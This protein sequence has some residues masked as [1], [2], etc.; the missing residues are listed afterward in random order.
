MEEVTPT[1]VSETPNGAEPQGE[2]PTPSETSETLETTDTSSSSPEGQVPEELAKELE[3]LKN[4]LKRAN[5]EAK[6]NRLAKEEL[7]RLKEEA[8]NAKLS[9]T[10][11][12][13][14]ELDELRTQREQQTHEQ[15]VSA[16]RHEAAIEAAKLGVDPTYLNKIFRFLEWDDI[17][18]DESGSPA[19]V[20]ELVAQLVKEIP[21]LKKSAPITSGGATNPPRS[22]TSTSPR[23]I[24]WEMI[25]SLTP[26]QYSTRS[27]EIQEWMAKHSRR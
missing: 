23:E 10:E 12:L 13:Q 19:N 6:E 27:R 25:A 15:F 20:G 18:S 7:Q 2:T 17:E 11:R 22:T 26:E 3:R 5:A 8:E 14:K 1:P 24:S 4:S 9:E 16:V 21:G